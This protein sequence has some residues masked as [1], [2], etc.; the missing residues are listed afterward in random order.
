MGTT[1]DTSPLAP[2]QQ[3]DLLKTYHSPRTKR[4][5]VWTGNRYLPDDYATREEAL[6]AGQAWIEKMAALRTAPR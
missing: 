6:A 2:D 1:T 3:R 4:Y 5:R